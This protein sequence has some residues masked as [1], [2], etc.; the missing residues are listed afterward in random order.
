MYI[1]SSQTGPIPLYELDAN[2]AIV[3]NYANTAGVVTGNA[4]PNINSVGTLGTLTVTG[5]VVGANI[6]GT[7]VNGTSLVGTITT[8]AQTNTSNM[9]NSVAPTS[10]VFTLGNDGANNR[11]GDSNVAYCWSE[12]KGFS[13]FG[14]YTG[15]LSTD[16]PFVYLG[17]RPRFIMFKRSDSTSQWAIVDSSRS[18]YNQTQIWLYPNLSNAEDNNAVLAIDF[19]SNGFKIRSTNVEVNASGGTQLYAAFAENPFRNALAR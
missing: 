11:S 6:I 10:S 8:A 7:V 17:F 13:A 1:F 18:P 12:V 15:N 4:Q 16:G 9:W 3:P 14:S 2:F 5:N 19:L